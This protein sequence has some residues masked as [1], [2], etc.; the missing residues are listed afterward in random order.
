MC[1]PSSLKSLRQR[2]RYVYLE[3]EANYLAEREA[4]A[5]ESKIHNCTR[6]SD[7]ELEYPVPIIAMFFSVV[8]KLDA[9]RPR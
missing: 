6:A 5:K 3:D 4:N 9:S 8:L 7:F 1:G 2:L